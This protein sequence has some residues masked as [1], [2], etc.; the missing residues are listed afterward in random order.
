MYVVLCIDMKKKRPG[1]HYINGFDRKTQ[2][3]EEFELQFH[4]TK[5]IT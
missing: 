5:G 4:I 3:Q 1:L 2:E